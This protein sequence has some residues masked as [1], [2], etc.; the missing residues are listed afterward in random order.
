MK[1]LLVLAGFSLFSSF[2]YADNNPVS[3][4]IKTVANDTGIIYV[5]ANENQVTINNVIV[6]RGNCEVQLHSHGANIMDPIVTTGADRPVN[7]RFGQ[8]QNYA[9]IGCGASKIIEIQV[10]TNYGTSTFTTR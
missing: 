8:E 3:V 5:Q 2:L 4:R 9:V 7:L 1:K 6:N 10:S